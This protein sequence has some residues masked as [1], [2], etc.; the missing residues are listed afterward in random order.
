MPAY[1][2]SVLKSMPNGLNCLLIHLA[3]DNDEMQAVTIDHDDYGS[4]WRQA[5]YDFFTSSECRKILEE[6]NIILVT[7]RELRDTITRSGN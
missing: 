2:R 1:Y 3:Y 7:W 6:E 5:D 4:N